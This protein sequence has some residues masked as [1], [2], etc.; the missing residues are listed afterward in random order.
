MKKWFVV[1]CVAL[2]AGLLFSRWGADEQ[3]L[4]EGY[5]YLPSYEAVDVGY[6][7]GPVVYK[8]AQKHVF[9]HIRIDGDLKGVHA[10]RRF[11]LAVRDPP[12]ASAAGKG[13]PLKRQGLQYFI[14]VKD[15]DAVYGP[16]TAVEYAQQRTRLGV[17]QDL[18]VAAE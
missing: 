4:G 13:V 17:P 5:Y 2:L 15:S 14:L 18:Q 7:G 9:S 3:E 8:A 12:A 11:I 10:N 6:P 16:Y 1:V